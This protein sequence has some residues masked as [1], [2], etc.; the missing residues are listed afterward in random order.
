MLRSIEGFILYRLTL[1]RND[2]EIKKKFSAQDFRVQKR[3]SPLP[4]HLHIFM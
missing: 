2:F 4:F 1:N 3:S